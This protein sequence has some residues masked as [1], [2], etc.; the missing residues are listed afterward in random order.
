MVE[1]NPAG[2][3]LQAKGARKIPP[4]M[5]LNPDDD[6]RV[7]VE[8]VFGPVLPIKTYRT[9]DEVVEYVNDHDRP[10]AL[11]YFGSDRSETGQRP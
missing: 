10:L 8:E 9:M 7:M 3:D 6:L 1:V 11:Y 4:T 5:I 2:E